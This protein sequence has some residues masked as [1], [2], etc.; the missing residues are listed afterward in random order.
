MKDR[1]FV[2]HGRNTEIRDDVELFIRRIGLEPIILAKQV[3][4]G[5][6]II[7]KI[8]HYSDVSCAIVLYTPCDEGRMK[9]DCDLKDR[10]R[11]NVIFEHGY[12][13]AKLG[14][15]N[16]ITLVESGMEFPGD[17]SGIVYISM[18]DKDWELQVMK[19]L[20]G[21]GLKIDWIQA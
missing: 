2:V 20:N 8:E 5:M 9:G 17:L 19:E 16:V 14:R 13:M 12:L 11:Q 6:S 4:K 10:A 21:V 1:I 15:N 7:E 18:Q 3:N